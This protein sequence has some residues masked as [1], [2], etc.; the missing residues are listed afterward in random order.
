LC[1]HC[2]EVGDPVEPSLWKDLVAPWRSSLPE[3][4]YKP[5]GC[6]ECRR[7]GYL[8]R[9]GLI[10]MLVMTDAMRK[11]ISE[12]ADLPQMRAQAARDG[13]RSLRVSGAEKIAR[14]TTTLDEV[15]KAAP[16]FV[17]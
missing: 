6:L 8:G 14:G 17:S 9:T 13:L 10:E 4:I 7:T 15:L 5:V 1:P 3:K 2:K 16:P 12:G 11:L